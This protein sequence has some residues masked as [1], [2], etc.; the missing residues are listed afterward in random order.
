MPYLPKTNKIHRLRV[1]KADNRLSSSQRG[2]DS[3]WRMVR[4]QHIEDNPL[5]YDCLAQGIYTEGRDVHHLI[6]LADRPDLRD[7]ASN[8]M[9]LCHS[10]HSIRTAKGE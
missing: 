5:C 10:C 8:L 3:S 1:V 2:Y 9:T 7:V 6:K 4:Q